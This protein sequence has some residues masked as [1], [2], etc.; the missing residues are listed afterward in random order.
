MTHHTPSGISVDISAEH[1]TTAEP[2]RSALLDWSPGLDVGI[3][4]GAV[5]ITF[6][7]GTFFYMTDG[8]LQEAQEAHRQGEPFPP[9]VYLL[10][11][12]DNDPRE[13]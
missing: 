8:P 6:A 2:L 11:F 9:G 1:A 4:D 10:H 7:A 5:D 3:A 13:D 12:I